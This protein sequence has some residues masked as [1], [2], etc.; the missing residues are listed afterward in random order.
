MFSPIYSAVCFYTKTQSARWNVEVAD[1]TVNVEKKVIALQAQLLTSGICVSVQ[2]QDGA[3]V[4]W[5]AD[6]LRPDVAAQFKLG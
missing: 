6:R 5:A 3:L 2:V 4:S 1:K